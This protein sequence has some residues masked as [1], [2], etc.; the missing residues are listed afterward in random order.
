M[1][2]DFTLKIIGELDTSGVSKAL[3][4]LKQE[5]ISLSL[6]TNKFESQ[7]KAALNS[8][9]SSLNGKTLNLDS[10]AKSAATSGQK[11]GKEFAASFSSESMSKILDS[12]KIEASI[13]NVSKQYK[14]L[15]SS[16]HDNI[17]SIKNDI[18][19][20]KTL[21]TKLFSGLNANDFGNAYGSFEKTLEKVKNNL[22]QV[23]SETT[24]LTDKIKSKLS[25]GDFD[26]QLAQVSVKFDKLS[27]SGVGGVDKISSGVAT[28]KQQLNQMKNAGSPEELVSSY[29][30]FSETLGQVKNNIAQVSAETSG[31]ASTSAI[32]T[33]DNNMSAWLSKNTKAVGDYGAAIAELQ[34]KLR[35]GDITYTSQLKGISE[36]F[37]SI[38]A[39]AAAAGKTGNSLTTVFNEAF[40][41]IAKYVSA[42]TIIYSAIS[43]TKQMVDN[44]TAVDTAM[45]DLKKVT[46]ET[47]E[48]YA[49]FLKSASSTSKSIGTTLSDYISSTADFS[50]LKGQGYDLDTSAGA[51]R[52][53][54]IYKVVGDG[55]DSIDDA[56]ESIVS[57]ATAFNVANTDLLSIVDKY[58]AVS[59]ALSIS[60]GG[61][62]DALQN[63]ASS[64]AA[65]NNSIDQSIALITG[66]NSI[67]QDPDKVGNGLKTISMRI[68]GV[69]TELEEA[70]LDTEG[71]ATS[72]AE[73]RASVEAIA[74]V[75]IMQDDDTFK[76]TYDILD[77]LS[78]K[79]QDLTDVQQ[80]S[81]TE[82]LAGKHQ[83]NIMESL[84]SN[85][86]IAREALDTSLNSSGSAEAE[87]SKWL[88]SIE[89]KTEQFKS[90][91]Q[92]LSVDLI[93]TDLVKGII[94]GGTTALNVLDTIINKLSSVPALLTAITGA[95]SLK[96]VGELIISSESGLCYRQENMPT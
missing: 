4:S 13:A 93:N 43:T 59:N 7:L 80:A 74:G 12:G 29:N 19:S 20:L 31:L 40:S 56:T 34:T 69:T 58:N 72:T 68:R 16:G 24:A 53:A 8:V 47:D 67:V 32:N 95:L 49:N 70:G 54:N 14:A 42:S 45:T 55:V 77:E 87:L 15:S 21:Q 79:W 38:K 2:E 11:A 71:M 5:K 51:A 90:S 85:F 75:D 84:M 62:G 88:E 64:L 78:L 30:K 50:K 91:F 81:L 41:S 89:A 25:V 35:S 26:T 33:L 57:T 65:A 52:V 18:D 39:S 66:A 82:L 44:V 76:S 48:S 94:D 61:I 22:S 6:D 73:L 86:D 3:E 9:S 96:G 27:S 1:A 23:S 36:Q 60:S 37:S 92:T 17:N 46:D 10:L 63:S 28:L 83:G